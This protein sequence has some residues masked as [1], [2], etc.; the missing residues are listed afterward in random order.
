MAETLTLPGVKGAFAVGLAWRHEDTV[1][2]GRVLRELSQEKGRWGV[3]YRTTAGTVQVGFCAPVDG[4]RVAGR[5]RSLAAMV[6]DSRPQPWMGLFRLGEDHYWYI[7]VR[8]GQEIIPDGDQ[9]GTHEA[10]MQVREN[11]LRLGDWNEC[12]GT[13]ADLAAV[14]LTTPRRPALRDFRARPRL[15]LAIT[16]GVLMVSGVSALYIK[17]ANDR[18]ATLALQKVAADAARIQQLQQPLPSVALAA[19][20]H[21]WHAQALAMSGWVLNTWSFHVDA[22]GMPSTSAS[23]QRAGG[24]ASDAPGALVTDGQHADRSS[25]DE[26]GPGTGLA[27]RTGKPVAQAVAERAIWSLAQTWGMTLT[28]EPERAG[29]PANQTSQGMATASAQAAVPWLERAVHFT[30]AMPPWKLQGSAFDAVPGLRVT[31]VSTD[32]GSGLWQVSGMLYTL[33]VGVAASVASRAGVA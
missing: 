28:I 29:N 4:V 24:L 6:A 32:T 31:E 22:A 30:T 33:R 21:A 2:K 18:E 12:E 14:V 20:A 10:V 17:Q 5:L 9:V 27:L 15:R 19:C 23:W 13:L 26:S 25:L 3:V 16:S 8:N 11:H 7:A 1:P